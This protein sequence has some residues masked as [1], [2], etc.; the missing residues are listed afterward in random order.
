MKR[1]GLTIATLILTSGIALAQAGGGGAGG[2][3]GSAGGATGS[4]ATSGT[5]SAGASPP[6]S[7]IPGTPGGPPATSGRA[8]GGA[9]TN[10][11]DQ[12]N[13]NNPQDLTK[14][15]GKNSQ[16]LRR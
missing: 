6:G 14:P 5:G 1:T 2:G 10:P 16:D 3:G 8:P 13:R 15:G 4:G 11:Q 12:G 9:A 7:T